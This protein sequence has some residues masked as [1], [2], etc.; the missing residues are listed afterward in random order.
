M[1]AVSKNVSAASIGSPGPGQLGRAIGGLGGD[2]RA[3]IP[4]KNVRAE[5]ELL[6][7]LMT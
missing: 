4:R 1:T 6:L 2:D 5:V 7:G 3:M